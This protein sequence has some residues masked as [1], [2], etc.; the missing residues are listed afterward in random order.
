MEVKAQIKLR[1]TSRA[2][3]AVVVARSFSLTRKKVGLAFKALDQT[4]QTYDPHTRAKQAT[5]YRCAD[6]DRLVP[7]LM[8]VS[9]AVLDNVVFVHQ[10]DSNWPLADTVTLKKRFDDLFAATKYTKALEALRKLRLETGSD[11]KKARLEA[12]TL[13]VTAGAAARLKAEGLAAHARVEALLA[14]LDGLAEAARNAEDE[15]ARAAAIAADAEA[16]AAAALRAG[17]AARA[18]TRESH[19]ADA[20]LGDQYGP[21]AAGVPRAALAADLASLEAL[22]SEARSSHAAAQRA[23]EA[24]ALRATT[25]AGRV[26]AADRDA[27]RAA[28]A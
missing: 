23:A 8:G 3:Q 22:T 28:A 1:L 13:A 16:A 17:E 19:R 5:T 14:A 20:R 18:A 12:A 15:A 21:A 2:G 6:M 11:A 4:V 26:A 25:L 9:P 7:G 27:A 24:A 10:E